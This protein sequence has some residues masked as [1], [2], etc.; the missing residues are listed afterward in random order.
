MLKRVFDAET[1]AAISAL[2]GFTLIVP[3]IFLWR[4]KD[5]LVRFWSAQSLVFFLLIFLADTLVL[6]IR[7]F[8]FLPSL[9]FI[10]TMIVWLIMVYKSWLGVKW[11]IPLIGKLVQRVYKPRGSRS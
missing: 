1:L 11:E 8:N 9:I 10:L 6:R 2:F 5:E 7:I 4:S 3:A